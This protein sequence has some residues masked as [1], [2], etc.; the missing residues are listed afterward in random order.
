MPTVE[1]LVGREPELKTIH[2]LVDGVAE[3]GGALVLRGEPGIGK[4]A[5]LAEAS[6]YAASEGFSVLAATGAQ[7]E[8]R[9][10]FAGLHQ[11]LQPVLDDA[12]ELPPP[13]RDALRSASGWRRSPQT[14]S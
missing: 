5:L 7:S 3:H 10:P 11:L 12:D 2:E 8:A 6:R 1:M 13:Q 9:L 14:R 4:S